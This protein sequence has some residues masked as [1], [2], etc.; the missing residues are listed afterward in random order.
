MYKNLF[1]KENNGI[2]IFGSKAIVPKNVT[3]NLMTLKSLKTF[4]L[5]LNALVPSDVER[6]F[7]CFKY[8]DG[9]K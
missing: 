9:D 5:D 3:I 8:T 2:D 1:V 4:S 6:L 7:I